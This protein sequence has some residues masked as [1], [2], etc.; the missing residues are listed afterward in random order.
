MYWRLSLS[1]VFLFHSGCV[2]GEPPTEQAAAK[3]WKSVAIAQPENSN[4]DNTTAELTPAPRNTQPPSIEQRPNESKREQVKKP[5]AIIPDDNLIIAQILQQSRARHSGNCACPD[6]RDKA[7]R[8]CGG[9]SAYSKPGGYAPLC[10]TSDVSRAMIEDAK[11][12]ILA[13]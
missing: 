13:R 10:Y 5:V 6:D 8:R 7:G 12:N 1:F 11:R 9:R 3:G 2:A 4:R